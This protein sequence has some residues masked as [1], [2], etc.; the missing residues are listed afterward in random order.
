MSVKIV[1]K[2]NVSI[3]SVQGPSHWKT[4]EWKEK[5]SRLWA[6]DRGLRSQ[7]TGPGSP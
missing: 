4:E 6:R 7:G 5:Y 3:L 2:D 1:L